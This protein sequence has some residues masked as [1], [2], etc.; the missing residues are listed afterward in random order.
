MKA[1]KSTKVMKF[2]DAKNASF[3]SLSLPEPLIS[4]DEFT[5]ILNDQDMNLSEDEIA[6]RRATKIWRKG[7]NS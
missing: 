2:I 7:L 3:E 4:A 1:K 6:L 5:K